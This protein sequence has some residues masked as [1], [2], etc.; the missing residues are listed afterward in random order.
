MIRPRRAIGAVEKRLAALRRAVA[1]E[2]EDLNR[3]IFHVLRGGVVLS[4]SFI[5]FAF[6]LAAATNRDLPQVTLSSRELGSALL[7]LTPAGFLSLGIIFM[8]LTP[9]ARV[10]LSL[11]S[12]A[13]ER[14]PTY[15]MITGIVL[16]N[17]VIGLLVGVG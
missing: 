17:L 6:A 16:V 3:L 13:K 10:V 9:V 7:H 5:L 11:L 1:A 8:I 2:V 14:D 15:V 12:Y 4:V